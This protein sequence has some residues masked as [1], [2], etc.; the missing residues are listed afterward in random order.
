MTKQEYDRYLEVSKRAEELLT[1]L[2]DKVN[3]FMI[4]ATS[5]AP[6]MQATYL[7]ACMS[8]VDEEILNALIEAHNSAPFVLYEDT[9]SIYSPLTG[10]G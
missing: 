10:E 8:N 2:R 6:E 3:S 1:E 7:F 4:A 9:D 5:Y